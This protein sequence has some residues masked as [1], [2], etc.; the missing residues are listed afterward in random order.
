MEST[1]TKTLALL[2]SCLLFSFIPANGQADF[3][4]ATHMMPFEE[5]TIGYNKAK[6]SDPISQLQSKMDK[7]EFELKHEGDSGFLDALL[8][9]LGIPKSSQ[10]LVFSKTSLQR[11]RISPR[12]PRALYFND[13]VY[14]GYIPGSP[15]VE[16]S[17][18]DPKL[19][20]VFYTLD[21]H[22]LKNPKFVRTDQCL[23][24][25]ASSKSM[26][27]PGHL[28]RSFETD[29]SG[30]VE[31]STGI[32][33]VNHRTPFEDRWGGWYVTGKH[34]EQ[35]HRGNLMGKAALD[36]QE[37]KP[38]H[39]GNLTDL[40][41]FFN[42]SRYPEK[43]SD[44]VALMVLEHQTHMHNFITR[45]NYESNIQLARYGH[46]NYISNIVESFLKYLL[47][48]EEATIKDGLEGSSTFTKDFESFGPTDSKGRSLRQFDLKKRVFKYPCSFLIYSKAFNELPAQ[49]KNHVYKR[50]W[51][52]LTE[53][54]TSGDFAAIA[55][56]TRRA[57]LEILVET[58]SD[59]PDY[60][61]TVASSESGN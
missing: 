35:T 61:K 51:E 18:V 37:K 50:L 45:L 48:T 21:Q 10:V 36:K 14:I 44:I 49:T 58:K 19:G 32:S 24:C 42:A 41:G 5:D 43:G 12:T 34:G 39:A 17:A 2:G 22:Q 29:E 16:V 20:G 28:V 40:S 31:L 59:L 38:N 26:G 30:V 52:I 55:S 54:D 7:G 25:H 33:I 23:E 15:I 53:K 60:W 4:G 56:G 46:M 1:W 57:I 3:Q 11:E 8:L 13:D 9:E 6:T 47:F 27:V